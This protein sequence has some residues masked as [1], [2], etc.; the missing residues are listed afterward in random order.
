[1]SGEAPKRHQPMHGQQ[2]RLDLVETVKIVA[3]LDRAIEQTL[4]AHLKLNMALAAADQNLLDPVIETEN[5]HA[6]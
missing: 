6:L 2:L 4:A 1:L 3:K 5:R